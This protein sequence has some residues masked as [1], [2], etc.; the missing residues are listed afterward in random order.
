ML[1]YDMKQSTQQ[2]KTEL[3]RELRARRRAL[4]NTQRRHADRAICRHIEQLPIFQ[5]SKRVGVFLAFDGEP[6][7]QQLT[8]RYPHKQF[9]IPLIRRERIVFVRYL[10][11]AA[12]RPNQFG[13]AEPVDRQR[14]S[15]SSMNLVL[16]S[17]VGFDLCG[18]RLGMGGGFY[19]RHFEKLLNRRA[20][21]HPEL[22]GVAYECQ[23]VDRLTTEPWDV[24]LRG[25][26]T[27]L[28][29]ARFNRGTQISEGNSHCAT[30]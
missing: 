9:F 22:I 12:Q 13:I 4:T 20:Y 15:T 17:L 11:N 19:D 16:A 23:Q 14:I 6:S 10:R 18:N 30:G 25:I 3:R 8:L 28:R 29:V 1:H 2:A 7:L 24:P 5:R 26:V 27:N 21:L